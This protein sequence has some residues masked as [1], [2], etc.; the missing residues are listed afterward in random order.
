MVMTRQIADQFRPCD[1][2]RQGGLINCKRAISI[3]DSRP[4]IQMQPVNQTLCE[5]KRAFRQFA[6]WLIYRCAAMRRAKAM[7][8]SSMVL[9]TLPL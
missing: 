5:G 8:L 6:D 1:R 2:C 3:N 7:L 4:E 9:S